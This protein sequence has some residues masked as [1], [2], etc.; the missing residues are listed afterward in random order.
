MIIGT[1]SAPRI[2]FC[3]FTEKVNSTVTN[4]NAIVGVDNDSEN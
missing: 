1:L 3:N 4:L 2:K